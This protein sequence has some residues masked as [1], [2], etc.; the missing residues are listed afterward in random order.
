MPAVKPRIG[1][2]DVQACR[3][4]SYELPLNLAFPP[5]P[6]SDVVCLASDNAGNARSTT[7]PQGL[8]TAFDHPAI[9]NERIE[10]A[11]PNASV[12]FGG[13]T[14]CKRCDA[15]LPGHIG[16]NFE[17]ISIQQRDVPCERRTKAVTLCASIWQLAIINDK[18]QIRLLRQFAKNG[19]LVLDGVC[20]QE[21]DAVLHGM[22]RLIRAGPQRR[23][24]QAQNNARI[25][26]SNFTG[27]YQGCRK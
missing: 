23:S 3:V 17:S 13:V 16:Q 22:D 11:L 10:S 21:S 1:L 5:G 25:S 2:T 15:R 20:C 19:N 8:K 14:P 4:L 26:P 24:C 12:Q 9:D 6:G 27:M 7:G 18:I